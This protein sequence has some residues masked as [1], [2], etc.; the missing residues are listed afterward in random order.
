METEK[1][2]VII[3]LI[4][5]FKKHEGKELDARKL[6]HTVLELRAR[7]TLMDLDMLKLLNS[8]KRGIN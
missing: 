4:E 7:L 5:D 8:G 6:H 2:K 1:E 3:E